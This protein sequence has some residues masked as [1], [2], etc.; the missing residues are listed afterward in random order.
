MMAAISQHGSS[1]SVIKCTGGADLLDRLAI[2]VPAMM[3]FVLEKLR[4]TE[5]SAIPNSNQSGIAEYIKKFCM[6]YK[7]QKLG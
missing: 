2:D 1:V 5:H 4:K 3:D 7:F 6:R